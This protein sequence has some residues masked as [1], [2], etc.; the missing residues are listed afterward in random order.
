MLGNVWEWTADLWHENYQDAP[1]AGEIWENKK[2]EKSDK[3]RRVVRG[4]SWR[5]GAKSCRSAC[6]NGFWPG[7][8]VTGFLG[9]RCVRVQ[10]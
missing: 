10:E 3:L 7:I 5:S 4:G 1:A 8:S 2:L 9:F 6:R